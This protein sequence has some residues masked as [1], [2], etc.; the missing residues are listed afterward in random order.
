MNSVGRFTGSRI[1]LVRLPSTEV[2]GYFMS[3]TKK[4]L[5]TQ[6]PG[7]IQTREGRCVCR[8]L[9]GLFIFDGNVT[10]SLRCGLLV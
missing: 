8:P 1:G 6:S 5:V 9:C 3:P 7:R 2:L 4:A 10:H